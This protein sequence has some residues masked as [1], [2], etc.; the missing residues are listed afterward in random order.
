MYLKWLDDEGNDDDR[1]TRGAVS[2]FF[3]SV[4]R[5]QAPNRSHGPQ[6]WKQNS[7]V[8]TFVACFFSEMQF[9]T[10][11]SIFGLPAPKLRWLYF[12]SNKTML[13]ATCPH[14]KN[15]FKKLLLKKGRQNIIT[16]WIPVM[17]P[18][19][20]PGG[21][22]CWNHC[23]SSVGWKMSLLPLDASTCSS[24]EERQCSCDWSYCTGTFEEY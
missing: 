2:F 6:R 11:S 13:L 16:R 5:Y 12:C 23:R 22:C 15:I 4:W 1:A 10:S 18:G 14:S 19:C 20:R 24:V 9:C 21:C 17:N 8:E 7:T 3:Q